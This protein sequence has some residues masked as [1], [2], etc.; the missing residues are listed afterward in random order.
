MIKIVILLIAL[1]TISCFEP[2]R[3]RQESSPFPQI[4][5]S[6]KL[7]SNPLTEYQYVDRARQKSTNGDKAGAIEDYS[8]AIMVDSMYDVAYY[9]RAIV[10]TYLGDYIGAI[11]D[12]TK[13]LQ[14][15]QPELE[16]EAYCARGNAK[17]ELDD[18][19]GALADYAIAIELRPDFVEAYL[20]RATV[21]YDIGDLEGAIED[22]R[23]A[24]KNC[25]PNANIYNNLG[26]A[27]YE[28]KR[29]NESAQA[30]GEGIK[31]F[32]K[33]YKLYYGRG[34]ARNQSGDKKGACEDWRK[35]S[36]LGYFAANALLP[37]CEDCETN[38]K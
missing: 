2:S 3:L 6:V 23:L 34:L 21:K 26:L 15:G 19:K 37:L 14:L 25:S 9:N 7:D 10:K 1:L 32:P 33:D 31:Y 11:K 20:S 24:I 27:L 36:A 17:S 28:L 22:C 13:V 35:S 8:R 38:E 4:E 5:Y 29:F 12:F 30:Y 16:L 18:I